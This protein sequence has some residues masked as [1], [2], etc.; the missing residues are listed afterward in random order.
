M[1]TAPKTLYTLLYTGGINSLYN[2]YTLPFIWLIL[3][4]QVNGTPKS[5]LGR[6]L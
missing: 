2:F 5:K 4:F 6:N 3:C 1:I